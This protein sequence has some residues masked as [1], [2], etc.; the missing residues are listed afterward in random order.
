MTLSY[1]GFY[2]FR[3]QACGRRFTRLD[4]ESADLES[5]DWLRRCRRF[6]L[7]DVLIACIVI[8]AFAILLAMR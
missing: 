8:V 3:R 1:A 4:R 7:H 6:Q 5:R 2:P